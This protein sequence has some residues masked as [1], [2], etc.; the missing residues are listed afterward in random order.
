MYTKNTRIILQLYVM[1]CQGENVYFGYKF[2]I[3][4][5]VAKQ[6]QKAARFEPLIC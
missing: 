5:C 2:D 3:K 1:C 6:K 4:I